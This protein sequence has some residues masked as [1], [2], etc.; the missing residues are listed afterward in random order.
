MLPNQARSLNSIAVASRRRGQ[1]WRDNV[2]GFQLLSIGFIC[3]YPNQERGNQRQP[4]GERFSRQLGTKPKGWKRGLVDKDKD[5]AK[6]GTWWRC[7]SME[8]D[9]WI[10]NV[11]RQSPAIC[12]SGISM[13]TQ[14]SIRHVSTVITVLASPSPALA[15]PCLV[16]PSPV[17]LC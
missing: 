17:L 12:T 7:R 15:G 8:K 10:S 14:F 1:G 5:K 6:L 2:F 4:L 11:E 3:W 9:G 16:Y 13:H